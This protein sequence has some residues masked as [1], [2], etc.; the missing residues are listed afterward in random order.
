VRRRFG[1][2]RAAAR[3]V[4][5]EP[6]TRIRIAAVLA[7]ALVAGCASSP[8]VGGERGFRTLSR[9]YQTGLT[10]TEP[11]VA[12]TAEQWVTLW[13][14]HTRPQIARPPAPPVDFSREMVVCIVLGDRPSSGFGVEV[15]SASASPDQLT[16]VARETRPPEGSLMPAVMTRPYH[17]I[18]T[19]QTAGRVALELR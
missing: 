6:R 7:L 10:G 3:L 18:A 1:A 13:G 15:E 2:T 11:R 9:G 16:I 8:G 12:R 5:V 19:E 4:S 17:M 14:E